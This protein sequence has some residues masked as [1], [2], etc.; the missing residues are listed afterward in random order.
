MLSCQL[1][2]TDVWI[3]ILLGRLNQYDIRGLPLHWIHT[4]IIIRSRKTSNISLQT[5][6]C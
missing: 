6:L 3:T 2:L 1:L 5:K 4:A